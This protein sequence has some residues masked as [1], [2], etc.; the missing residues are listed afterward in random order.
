MKKLFL[1]LALG[2][3]CTQTFAQLNYKT[4]QSPVDV[5]TILGGSAGVSYING[6]YHLY[7]TTSNQYDAPILITLGKT[8]AQSLAT[9]ADLKAL[10]DNFPKDQDIELEQGTRC[11]LKRNGAHSAWIF[12]PDRA[13]YSLLERVTVNG[14]IR[15]V[16]AF[17]PTWSEDTEGPDTSRQPGPH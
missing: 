9:L 12:S 10:L 8:K 7:L 4:T 13:G 3:M 5:W 16:E 17:T 14:A 2:L 6:A 15:G 11:T 1:M